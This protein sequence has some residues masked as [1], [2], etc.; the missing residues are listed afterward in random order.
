MRNT[1]YRYLT[2]AFIKHCPDLEA[3]GVEADKAACIFLI[4]DNVFIKGGKI[5][6][7]ARYLRLASCHDAIT[8][9]EF[10]SYSPCNPDL[11][12]I[13]KALSTFISG[14]YQNP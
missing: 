5:L 9:I 7:V 8:L 4:I 11:A 2:H 1:Y 3:Q 6:P 13:T 10:H 12:F 14:E